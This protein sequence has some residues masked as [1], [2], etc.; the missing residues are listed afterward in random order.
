[1]WTGI[2]RTSADMH[3][4]FDLQNAREYSFDQQVELVLGHERREQTRFGD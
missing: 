3:G 4:L 1:M 2:E